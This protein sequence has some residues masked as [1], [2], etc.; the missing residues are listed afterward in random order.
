MF[1]QQSLNNSTNNVR[2]DYYAEKAGLGLHHHK[3][4]DT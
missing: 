4:T 2:T 1:V 3:E